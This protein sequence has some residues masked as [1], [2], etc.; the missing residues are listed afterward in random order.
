M[1]NLSNI[2]IVIIGIVIVVGAIWFFQQ[3]NTDIANF[4]VNAP[5]ANVNVQTNLN[6]SVINTNFD[7]NVGTPINTTDL[8][9]IEIETDISDL[10]SIEADLEIPELDFDVA[11]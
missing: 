5:T 4:S 6:N 1:K 7:T 3:E 2:I 8:E 11:F 9:A 10:S